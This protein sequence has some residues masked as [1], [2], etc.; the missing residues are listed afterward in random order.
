M[1]VFASDACGGGGG[2]EALEVQAVAAKPQLPFEELVVVAGRTQEAPSRQVGVILD[3]GEVAAEFAHDV[4]SCFPTLVRRKQQLAAAQ[5]EAREYMAHT[6]I[7][8]LRSLDE[9]PLAFP[10]R[11][12]T[13]VCAALQREEAHA[14]AEAGGAPV[15][16]QWL[17][18]D[19]PALAPPPSGSSAAAPH[20]CALLFSHAATSSKDEQFLSIPLP[21]TPRGFVPSTDEVF[22]DAT[23]LSF[24]AKREATA[25]GGG[26]T[27]AE[28][29]RNIRM[30]HASGTFCS[31]V[32][33]AATW[34]AVADKF[35]AVV[36]QVRGEL[37]LRR[38][39]GPAANARLELRLV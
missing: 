15:R 3:V 39:L 5:R 21:R 29:V 34:E 1:F 36:P 12:F 4:R 28:T 33:P 2:V 38:V 32:E 35:A 22:A 25:H 30:R 16:C 24:G 23:V 17:C 11:D 10:I 8:M 37:R 19:L 9:L 27:P 20:N 31:L 26:K 18:V 14:Q 6:R 13:Q 7:K